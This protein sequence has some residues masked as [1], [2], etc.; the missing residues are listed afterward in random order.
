MEPSLAQARQY[1]ANLV[2]EK[3]EAEG[4]GKPLPRGGPHGKR[5]GTTTTTTGQPDRYPALPCRALSLRR[6]LRR[7]L[8]DEGA[9]G[10]EGRPR[11]EATPW[12]LPARR[13]SELGMIILVFVLTGGFYTLSNLGQA[14][15]LPAGIIPFL[16]LVFVLMLVAHLSLRW[17]APQA[18]PVLLPLAA[19]LNG[20][21]YVF[22]ADL[23]HGEASAQ[24]VWTG[25]GVIA[26][27]ITLAVCP[28]GINL[29]RY[30]YSLALVGVILLLL[31]LAPH[32]GEDINGAQLWVHVG[33]LSFQPEEFAKLALGHLLRLGPGRA[34]GT[35]GD[36]HT[37]VRALARARTEV[38]G[39]S[40]GCL[41]RFV[42]GAARRKRPR[43]VIPILRPRSSAAVG[44]DGESRL[45][46]YVGAVL[47]IGAPCSR[48]T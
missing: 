23:N 1:I 2:A 40:S 25:V 45:I 34:G 4:N 33:P 48:S 18:D 19:L 8:P 39:P 13:R 30:R 38:P 32:I 26:F 20:M 27:V 16:V 15:A 11:A 47:F 22:I 35:V 29:E 44:G 41:G 3:I 9:P 12:Q 5:T 31:P 10:V 6:W 7:Q 14:G 24:A 36:R 37:E 42:A 17:L 43:F 46:L 28:R 21:G